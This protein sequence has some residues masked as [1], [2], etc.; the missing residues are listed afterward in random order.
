[1]CGQRAMGGN[2]CDGVKPLHY[3]EWDVLQ[4]ALQTTGHRG[5][6]SNQT[7]MVIAFQTGGFDCT[8]RSPWVFKNNTSDRQHHTR[9]AVQLTSQPLRHSPTGLYHANLMGVCTTTCP[10]A[11]TYMHT[12][13][14]TLIL[15]CPH[16]TQLPHVLGLVAMLTLLHRPTCSSIHS[17]YSKTSTWDCREDCEAC[18][19]YG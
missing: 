18:S 15:H 7:P 17:G 14:H 8:S 5:R 2:A 1:M 3:A 19:T 11:W 4:A 12:H 6:P 13:M 10:A 16:S 9:Q